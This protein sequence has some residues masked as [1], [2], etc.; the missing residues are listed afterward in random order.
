MTKEQVGYIVWGALAAA[1]A[2]PEILA[3]FGK[4]FVPWP[5]FARTVNYLQARKP[6]LTMFLLALFAI[7]VVHIVFYPW[8]TP[9][10]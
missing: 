2:I 10:E 3:A 5:G 1:V 4:E 6:V 9:L 7:L 8:P